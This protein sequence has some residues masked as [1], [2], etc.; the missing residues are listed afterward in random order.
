MCRFLTFRLAFRSLC[1]SQH[2]SGLNSLSSLYN[3][4]T[5]S[6]IVRIS[7]V[8][9]SRACALQIGNNSHLFYFQTKNNLHNTYLSLLFR[10]QIFRGG[11]IVAPLASLCIVHLDH[12]RKLFDQGSDDIILVTGSWTEL[13]DSMYQMPMGAIIQTFPNN[14]YI[15]LVCSHTVL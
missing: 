15:K 8:V 2:H 12:I 3:Q 9:R 13:S 14:K 10:V 5:M 1:C 7:H 11:G 4:H 6:L